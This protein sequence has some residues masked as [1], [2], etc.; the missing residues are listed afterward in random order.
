MP[1]RTQDLERILSL[2]ENLYEAIMIVA[3]RARQINEEFYQKKRDRQIR[4]ELDGS[5]EEEL[6]HAE[7]EEWDMEISPEEEE[8][9]VV[10]ALQEFLDGRL[11][12]H[13]EPTR[14]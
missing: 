2:S 5:F 4:E 11:A 8:N 6:L 9:P 14:G 13:Y 7:A 1:A 10:L 3:K 12:Y